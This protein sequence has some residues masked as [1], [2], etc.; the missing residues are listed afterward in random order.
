MT[1]LPSC[2][3]KAKMVPAGQEVRRFD[4]CLM[5]GS[6]PTVQQQPNFSDC[7]IYL[8]QYIES[9]FRDPI[10]DYNLPIKSIRNWF[11]KDEVEGKRGFIA[12]LIRK[13][14]GEQNP[15]KEF[16]FPQL[17]F[18]NPEDKGEESEEEEEE[19]EDD[20]VLQP[21]S[22]QGSGVVRLSSGQGGQ[23][24]G[25]G[26]LLVTPAKQQGKVGR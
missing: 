6:Q 26:R 3:W 18:L 14:A 24:L 9:F 4:T 23:S 13:L 21:V 2:E 8:L 16:S 12:E 1:I 15:G 7:G 20:G 25:P 17:N 19:D 11:P 22:S 10:G 5:P